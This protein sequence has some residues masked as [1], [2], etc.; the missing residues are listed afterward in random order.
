M[1]TTLSL[2][3]T[4]VACSSMATELP[5]LPSQQKNSP[6]KLFLSSEA[7][8]HDFDTW[9]I[10]GGYSYNVFDNIDL[11]VGARVNQG[12]HTNESGFL[13]GVSYQI[14]PRVSVKSTLHS[15]NEDSTEEGTDKVISA[16]VSSRMRLTE[17]LDLHATLEHQ[18][19][20]QELEV[21]I[22]FR[23]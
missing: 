15:Y 7:N 13:S 2:L 1:K 9:K 14:T 19:W 21:G 23:F 11:Y 3:L 12:N 8:Q 17:N 10:D 16:E 5:A 18:E 22:G 20:Q 4:L 6:H